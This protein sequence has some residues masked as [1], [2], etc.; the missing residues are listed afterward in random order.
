[1]PETQVSSAEITRR[2]VESLKILKE[3][4]RAWRAESR[5]N[6][7]KIVEMDAKIN[8]IA[9]NMQSPAALPKEM[10][11]LQD[12]STRLTQQYRQIQSEMENIV[13]FNKKVNA[14]KVMVEELDRKSYDSDK[15]LH[16][17]LSTL[18]KAVLSLNQKVTDVEKI[19]TRIADMKKGPSPEI[20]AKLSSL[21]LMLEEIGDS[22]SQLNRLKAQLDKVESRTQENLAE[23]N[24]LREKV[25]QMSIEGG[26]E[27]IEDL[28]DRMNELADKMGKE[29]PGKISAE[30]LETELGS[31]MK[32]TQ[33]NAEAV[34]SIQNELASLRQKA[35][36]TRDVKQNIDEINKELSSLEKGG[37]KIED[38][39]KIVRKHGEDIDQVYSFIGKEKLDIENLAAVV[40][41]FDKKISEWE[42]ENSKRL[43]EIKGM[44]LK[45][46]EVKEGEELSEEEIKKIR[47]D[48]SELAVSIGKVEELGEMGPEFF[49]GMKK[50]LDDWQ[51]E[52]QKNAEKISEMRTRLKVMAKKLEKA[53]ELK[54]EV[55]GLRNDLLESITE[56]QEQFSELK[57]SILQHGEEFE[58]LYSII[59]KEELDLE[60][61]GIQMSGFRGKLKEW[62]KHNE[63]SIKQSKSLQSKLDSLRKK[64]SG[65][66]G[67]PIVIEEMEEVMAELKDLKKEETRMKEMEKQIEALRQR[68]EETKEIRNEMGELQEVLSSIAE[69]VKSFQSVRRGLTR[70]A[71]ELKDIHSIVEE[72]DVEIRELDAKMASF[73]DRL[74]EWNDEVKTNAEMTNE[75][76]EKLSHLGERLSGD[77]EVD[78]LS[79]ELSEINKELK[80]IEKNQSSLQKKQEEMVKFDDR[81]EEIVQKTLRS[82]VSKK[83]L[84]EGLEKIQEM[85]KKS[86]SA[87]KRKRRKTEAK[88]L[89][90]QEKDEGLQKL[91]EEFT[92]KLEKTSK[93]KQ[94]KVWE[95]YDKKISSF[96]EESLEKEKQAIK[97]AEKEGKDMSKRNL[98]VAKAD[99]RLLS[100]QRAFS[101]QNLKKATK[102]I[103]RLA[104]LK[105]EFE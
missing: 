50:D 8:T 77:E 25:E 83:E 84:E 65:K 66:K 56:T 17:K 54:S 9:R 81:I 10:A 37:L 103:E 51:E 99:M 15:A 79:E 74:A 53:D 70:H 40:D 46:G 21:R 58:S 29:S 31:W 36:E 90:S 52:T 30:Q 39:G 63:E 23:M 48:I 19:R 92:K 3:E 76:S 60:K 71:E 102:N 101:S 98:I 18:E 28:R 14:L 57:E 82:N 78:K 32:E 64:V 34:Q 86:V 13:E 105:L 16:G 11:D 12:K 5:Q 44:Q 91:F 67:L 26:G 55:D 27:D 59:G 38:I 33:A 72:R 6:Q 89:A 7:K 97:K 49:K 45:L 2:L 73:K 95:E 41:E 75:L 47:G 1:M 43:E 61:I 24:E 87:A 93:K 80:K 69:N 96:V 35:E 88:R 20:D 85:K 104:E 100:L 68:M 4:L 62:K 94:K 22:L 42:Q